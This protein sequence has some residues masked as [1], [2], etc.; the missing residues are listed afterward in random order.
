MNSCLGHDAQATKHGLFQTETGRRNRETNNCNC[1][2]CIGHY[3][4][5]TMQAVSETSDAALQN[6]G[7]VDCTSTVPCRRFYITGLWG[8]SFA[9]LN[10]PSTPALDN[11]ATVFTAGIAAG[12]SF[13]RQRGRLRVEVEGLGRDYYQ[14]A[15]A[16]S[17]GNSAV[18][19]NNWSVTAN[20][21]RDFM[22]TERFGL[23]GGGGI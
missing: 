3:R 15:Y 18:M 8:P 12:M 2:G 4:F 17:P 11:S 9:N 7:C 1:R 5:H 6:V 23:Y 14:S 21:W 10:S 16:A 20:A 22:F 13:E 19:V